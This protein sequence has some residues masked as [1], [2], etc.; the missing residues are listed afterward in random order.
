M[1]HD[2]VDGTGV[3]FQGTA[4]LTGA[5]VPKSDRWLVAAGDEQFARRVVQDLVDVM[6]RMCVDPQ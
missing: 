3:T 2:G 1:Q 4:W 5:R 6:P